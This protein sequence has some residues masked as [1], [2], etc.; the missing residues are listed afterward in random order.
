MTEE[1]CH[2]GAA[3]K[4]TVLTRSSATAKIVHDADV[5]AHSLSL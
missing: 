2:T 3:V 4:F 5:G 1:A